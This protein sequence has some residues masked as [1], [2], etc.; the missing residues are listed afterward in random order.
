[1]KPA[2]ISKILESIQ[3]DIETIEDPKIKRLVSVL[4]NLVEVLASDNARVRQENQALKDEIN[5]LKG[6]QGKRTLSQIEGRMGI[7]L[8]S[9]S[10]NRQRMN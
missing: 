2:D 8:P 6:E 3:P 7:F 4:L 5:R 10:A 9:K 1:M